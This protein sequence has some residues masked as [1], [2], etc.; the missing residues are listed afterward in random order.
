MLALDCEVVSYLSDIIMIRHLLKLGLDVSTKRDLKPRNLLPVLSRQSSTETPKSRP[1]TTTEDDEDDSNIYDREFADLK[2]QDYE[3][4]YKDDPTGDTKKFIESVLTEYEYLKYNSMGR[5]PSNIDLIDMKRFIEEASGPAAREK[6]F[7]FFYKREMTKRANRIKKERERE[8]A[9]VVRKEKNAKFSHEYGGKR[10]GLLTD[11]GK[12]IY[13]LWHNTLFCRIPDNKLKSGRSTSRLINA[14]LYGR[15]LI[16]DFDFENQMVPWIARNTM[17]QVQ[18]AYGLN[19]Y[20]YKDPFD[21][22][23]CNFNPNSDG[24]RFLA[25]NCMKNLHNGSL[26]TLKNDCFTNHFDKSRLVYLSPNARERLDDINNN[27][28]DVYIIGAYNDKGS[29]KPLTYR[30][31]EALGIR[32]RSLPINTY[33][34]LASGSKSLCVNHVTG[35]LLE[36][37]ANGG[38]W[39]EA[40]IKYIPQRKIKP[41]E[42]VMEEEARRMQKLRKKSM[43]KFSIRKDL[44]LS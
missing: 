20:N 43:V 44:D 39:R 17:E 11:E 14:A 2:L 9:K 28:D 21:I 10:T 5:V 24:G 41:L 13:G 37:M 35:I 12:L 33:V 34:S 42:V 31:A 1:D 30:K 3:S 32:C 36:V 18:E 6:L 8:Q 7:N 15:K 22:W 4:L 26:V 16:F 27:P 40:L 23:F 25:D 38:N 29:A 19:R